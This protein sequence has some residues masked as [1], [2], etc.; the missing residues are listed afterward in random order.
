MKVENEIYYHISGNNQGADFIRKT[1][2][3]LIG[4]ETFNPTY[5]DLI[6]FSSVDEKGKGLIANF[7]NIIENID[8]GLVYTEQQYY[9]F[10]KTAINNFF[11]L[12]RRYWEI[13]FEDV[14][15][16]L[17]SNFPSRFHSIF[18][19]DKDNLSKWY[20]KVIQPDCEKPTIF[21][22]KVTGEIHLCDAEWLEVDY[23]S[24]KDYE[25]VAHKYWKGELKYKHKTE[26]L[27]Y[28]FI[29]KLEIIEEY[30]SLNEFEEKEFNH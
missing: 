14:R 15:K 11:H 17:F 9:D 10:I 22:F 12:N 29:G 4:K 21:K 23:L 8:N 30:K 20:E 2:P 7:D 24:T 1:T 16:K 3:L 19:C 26:L 5:K 28:L 13:I 25:E 27:E 6:E 18:L